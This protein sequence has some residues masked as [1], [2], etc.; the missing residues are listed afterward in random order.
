LKGEFLWGGDIPWE[1]TSV[2]RKVSGGIFQERGISWYYLK[3]NEKLN[4]IK[5]FLTERKDYY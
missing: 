3:N 1:D 5:S 4:K 2:G